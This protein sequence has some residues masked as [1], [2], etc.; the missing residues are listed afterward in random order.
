M[1]GLLASRPFAAALTGDASLRGRP[2]RRV[3]APLT[4]MGARFRELGEPDRFPIEVAGGGLSSIDYTSPKASAQVKSAIL[5][6]A[7]SGGV[8]ASVAEPVLSRDHTERMLASLGVPISSESSGSGARAIVQPWSGTFPRLDL[9]VPGDPSS[10]AF[11]AALALLADTGELRIRGVCVNPTRTGFFRMVR[12]MGGMM[13]LS[14]ERVE[15]ASPWPTCWCARP[16]CA[17]SRS[18]GARSR[19]RS[20]RSPCWPRSPRARRARRASPAPASCG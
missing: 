6:A 13:E 10:A 19:R 16:R 4:E 7:V 18:A 9:R 20:T 14:N 2:M 12:H 15:G 1:L 3:T 8:A 17:A 11:L 5:L